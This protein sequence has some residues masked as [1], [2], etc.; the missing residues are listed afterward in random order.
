MRLAL[1]AV[2]FNSARSAGPA[3]AGVVIAAYGTAGSYSVQALCYF[4]ATIWTFMLRRDQNVD[5]VGRNAACQDE[6]FVRTVIEG[7]QFS[8]RNF[9]VRIGMMVVSISMFLLIPF[10]TLLPVFARDISACRRQRPG[11]ITNVH[12][13]RRLVQLGGCRIG[14]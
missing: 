7:W 4:L 13:H 1:N 14:G 12:G 9:E 11:V 5:A 8:W 3:L 10:T 2:V 6:S